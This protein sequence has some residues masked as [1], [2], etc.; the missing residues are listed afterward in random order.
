MENKKLGIILIIIAIVFGMFILKTNII[1]EAQS[2][3]LH[4]ISEGEC[5]TIATNTGYTNMGFGFFG[6]MIGL[7]FF[8][9]FFNKT[10]SKILDKLNEKKETF[11]DEE[12]F[13]LILKALDTHERKV[14]EKIK[15]QDGIT[16][17]TL[18]IRSGLSKTKLSYVLQELEKREL[19]A[20]VPHKRTKQ[21]FIKI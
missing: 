6:F 3:E 16:Q 2:S 1:L 12:R 9:L 7:G 21:V 17:S 5:T 4:C 10:E 13:N 19:I 18:M 15:E 20:R 8:I 11:K 14:M